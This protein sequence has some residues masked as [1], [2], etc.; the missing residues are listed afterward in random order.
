MR[1]VE[2]GVRGIRLVPVLVVM[3]HSDAMAGAADRTCLLDG[4]RL[5]RETRV[6]LVHPRTCPPGDLAVTSARGSLRLKDALWSRWLGRGRLPVRI[7]DFVVWVQA[8][9]D[10]SLLRATRLS[11]GTTLTLARGS[12]LP[13]VEQSG[14]Y[15][16]VS[17]SRD[18]IPRDVVLAI[19]HRVVVVD[20]SDVEHPRLAASQ[21]RSL[22]GE[23]LEHFFEP[24]D[25]PGTFWFLLTGPM[26]FHVARWRDG[27]TKRVTFE[28]SY[29]S[30][31]NLAIDPANG[32]V[33]FV[34]GESTITVASFD[35]APASFHFPTRIGTS[36]LPW[37]G[38]VSSVVS[39]DANAL[40]YDWLSITTYAL[41]RRRFA[42]HPD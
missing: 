30:Y 40:T 27:V 2:S 33:A 7:A 16:A 3:A 9:G 29:G 22:D 1:G 37:D 23:A 19:P 35:R 18:P 25:A 32:S 4:A 14:A 11:N 6:A 42:L 8:D 20:F 21:P 34:D 17:E 15:L 10:R 5:D 31:A 12:F 41:E 26:G 39:L 28:G 38:Y 36:P 13:E 24:R